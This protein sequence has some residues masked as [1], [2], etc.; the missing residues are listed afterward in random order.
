ML[1][2]NIQ[3]WLSTPSSM[4]Y[5]PALQKTL[6]DTMQKCFLQLVAEVPTTPMP[7]RLQSVF[8]LHEANETSF[9]W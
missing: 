2:G 3:R 5:D 4:A 9:A 7:S 8:F 6:H 1:I